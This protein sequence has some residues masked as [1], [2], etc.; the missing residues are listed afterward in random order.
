M[1]AAAPPIQNTDELFDY[2]HDYLAQNDGNNEI[3]P[4]DVPE[5]PAAV[6]APSRPPITILT[7]TQE[8]DAIVDNFLA[9]IPA[10]QYAN[11]R[12]PVRQNVVCNDF[13]ERPV[14][15][16]WLLRTFPQTDYR[17]QQFPAASYRVRPPVGLVLRI[18]ANGKITA[19]GAATAEETELGLQDLRQTLNAL[20][21]D[22]YG[23]TPV[24]TSNIVASFSLPYYVKI[25]EVDYEDAAGFTFMR[26]LFPGL[27]YRNINPKVTLLIFETGSVMILGARS[28]NA[29]LVAVERI[30]QVLQRYKVER[31]SI[32][33]DDF[34]PNPRRGMKGR[35]PV[36]PDGLTDEQ[37][38]L[39]EQAYK[40]DPEMLTRRLEID[41]LKNLASAVKIRRQKALAAV[42]KANVLNKR[43]F[44]ELFEQLYSEI[45]YKEREKREAAERRRTAAA[46]YF[47]QAAAP[48]GGVE[49]HERKRARQEP[50]DD[51]PAA[52][53]RQHFDDID[54]LLRTNLENL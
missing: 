52:P 45:I 38:A 5:P 25:S 39:V 8:D 30:D 7:Q 4:F 34:R 9:L 1:A 13:L 6:A 36:G 40:D 54:E 20:G 42:A 29:I 50:D 32:D 3:S 2:I 47:P 17:F 19:L 33:T 10:P 23:M 26:Q 15:M 22:K 28:Y 27:I 48:E 43:E 35:K 37:R 44:E 18:F 24:F 51:G 16:P 53:E 49:E 12:M 14:N 11:N 31:D 21:P 46:S 41:D